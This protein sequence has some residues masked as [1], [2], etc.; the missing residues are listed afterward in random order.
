MPPGFPQSRA[1]FGQ[2]NMHTGP[3]AGTLSKTARET[4]PGCFNSEKYSNN[5]DN[6]HDR[7]HP[8]RQVGIPA[9]DAGSA[10]D[11]AGISLALGICK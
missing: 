4:N 8:K 1:A 10:V 5:N 3:A 9:A 2:F 6:Q 7:R 11:G